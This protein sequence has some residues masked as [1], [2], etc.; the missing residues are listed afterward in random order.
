MGKYN[1]EFQDY[2][3]IA[4][5]MEPGFVPPK[6]DHSSVGAILMREKFPKFYHPVAYCIAG[7]HTGLPDWFGGLDL[8]LKKKELYEAAIKFADKNILDKTFSPTQKIPF[9]NIEQE[10][11][12]WIRM[13][14]SCLVDADW[15]DTER[16]MQPEKSELRGRYDSIRILK[17]RFDKYLA[18]KQADAPDT[19]INKLR[20]DVSVQCRNCGRMEPGLYSL[21]VPTG[22]GKTLAS[23]AWALEHAV[24]YKKERI[25]VAIPYT[26]IITQT[27][28]VYRE[29]FGEGNVVEHHSNILPDEVPKDIRAAMENWDA[30]VIVTTNV[31]LFESLYS[32]KPSKCRKLHNLVN[33]VIILDEAQML[34]VE[35]LKPVLQVLQGL[36]D[37]FGASILFCTATQPVFSGRIGGR[38][39]IFTGLTGPVHEIV[40]DVESVF[41]SLSRV[42]VIFPGNDQKICYKELAEEL[43]KYTQ[44]LCIVNTRTEARDIYRLMPEGTLHLSRMMCSAHILDTIDTIKKRLKNGEPVRVIS[45][46]LIEA[47]VDIDFP[48]VYRAFA[49]LDSIV[50]A[51][52]RCNRE[53][54]LK[55]KGIVKVFRT[56]HRIPPGL[57]SKGADTL[58]GMLLTGAY[59][60]YLS[61]E[62]L[63]EYFRKYYMEVGNFD[64]A[65]IKSLLY[66]GYRNFQFQF[67]EAASG[68][69][70]ID[71]KDSVTIAVGYGGGAALIEELK[72]KGPEKELLRRMQ[73][74]SVSVHSRDFDKLRSAGIVAPYHDV[75]VLE[76]SGNYDDSVGLVF[77]NKWLQ[78][79]LYV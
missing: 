4:S 6:V 17:E 56:D 53:G 59:G 46:Q 3:H 30:P 45:T 60:N 43:Q 77:E 12:L 50:Q 13:L 5:G 63:R 70:L 10:M 28:A 44:V 42:S 48:V 9:K 33:T 69:R 24:K 31:Q 8:R 19:D 47:G 65:N 72:S 40:K 34:P 55:E 51:A 58:Q 1:K 38:Q 79:L 23:M 37:T 76:N 7:H 27:A 67:A 66:E 15:L 49:G 2:I 21:T 39:G 32:N 20:S 29:I 11:H 18:Q 68:F 35:F 78:E 16:F 74:Y 52:G 26:S 25:I 14:F 54:K 57:I 71:D 41:N 64:R 73:R 75:Y 22:G 61:P 36:R 62:T